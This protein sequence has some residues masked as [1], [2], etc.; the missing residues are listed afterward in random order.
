MTS[1]GIVI[2][3][4]KNGINKINAEEMLILFLRHKELKDGEV[5]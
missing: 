1:K 5:K 3:K 4:E 2:R